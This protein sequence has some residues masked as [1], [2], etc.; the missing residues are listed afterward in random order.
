[1]QVIKH[2]LDQEVTDIHRRKVEVINDF[3]IGSW[4]LATLKH[5][6]PSGIVKES[7]TSLPY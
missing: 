1:L 3:P 7:C 6:Y 5:F 2:C 4:L